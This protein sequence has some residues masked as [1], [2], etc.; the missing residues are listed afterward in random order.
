MLGGTVPAT[1][2]LF[3]PRA[4]VHAYLVTAHEPSAKMHLEII[5][6]RISASERGNILN[7]DH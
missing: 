2:R 5:R 7:R 6:S 3:S 4:I 1:A